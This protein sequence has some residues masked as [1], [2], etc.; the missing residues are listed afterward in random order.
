MSLATGGRRSWDNWPSSGSSC[1]GNTCS[2]PARPVAEAFVL[3]EA[4]RTPASADRSLDSWA[5]HMRDWDCIPDCNQVDHSLG[6]PDIR[7]ACNPASLGVG[8]CFQGEQ[9]RPVSGL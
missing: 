9:M 5:G 8:A 4:C 3:V 1:L 6:A 7:M 2:G